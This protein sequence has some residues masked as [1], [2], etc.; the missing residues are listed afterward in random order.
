MVGSD[1]M[2]AID[3][4]SRT[5]R[6]VLGFAKRAL[7]GFKPERPLIRGKRVLAPLDPF[8]VQRRDKELFW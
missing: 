1:S 6:A 5:H 4:P 7:A 8:A 3:T 2:P